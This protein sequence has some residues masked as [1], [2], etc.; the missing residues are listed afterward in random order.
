MTHEERVA[1]RTKLEHKAKGLFERLE[2]AC[3]DT[4]QMSLPEMSIASDIMK[5]LSEV[6][7]NIAKI[8]YYE[9]ERPHFEEK[10]Y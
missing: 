7:K 1:F 3:A 4:Q 8:H 5:D 9:S 6:E 10:R 2:R